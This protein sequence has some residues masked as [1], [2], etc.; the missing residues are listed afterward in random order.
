MRTLASVLMFAVAMAAHGQNTDIEA[1]SGLQFNFSNPGARALAMGGAFIGLAD[2]ASAAIANPA[3]LTTLRKPEFSVEF[4]DV[5]VSQRFVTGGTYP[6]VSSENFPA[7]ERSIAFAS[8]V[9]PTNN[10]VFSAYYHRALSIR[11]NIQGRFDTPVFFLGPS[12][13]VLPEECDGA[14]TLHRLYPFNTSV[15]LQME[16]FGVAA[17]WKWRTLS[18]GASARYHQFAENADTFRRDLDAPGQPVFT[19]GQ[20]NATR[21]FGN[22]SDSNVTFAGGLRWTPVADLSLGAAFK[23]GP[24]FPVTI[25]AGGQDMEPELIATTTFHVPTTAGIGASYRPAPQLTLNADIVHVQYG[26]LTDDFVS[27]IEYGVENGGTVEHVTGYE[28]SDG[29]E[30]HAGVEYFILTRV[31]VGLR[32]GWWRDPAHSIEY[33][34]AMTTP[35]GVSASILF[36]GSAGEDHYSVGIGLA[37]PRFGLD[38]AYDTSRSLKTASVSVIVRK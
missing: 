7:R 25:V 22:Q 5:T 23:K 38:L 21:M 15:D 3:G 36:P 2:D 27:V 32:A 17:A 10:G 31:P 34:G 16:T 35:H 33:R 1:L 24:S 18:F 11:N 26:K 20:T 13:P 9:L 14:C 6:Q 8:A 30:Y 4:R 28:T 29:I 12:G 19:V 37:T